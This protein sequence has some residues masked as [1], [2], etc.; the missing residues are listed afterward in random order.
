M[1]RTIIDNLKATYRDS[2]IDLRLMH[3]S[4]LQLETNSYVIETHRQ[5]SLIN[6]QTAIE[7][8]ETESLSPVCCKLDKAELELICKSLTISKRVNEGK[9]NPE[10][11]K[12]YNATCRLLGKLKKQLEALS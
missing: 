7:E 10:A 1:N 6:V 4:L 2:I 12:R 8:L 3:I 5:A 11:I 9:P